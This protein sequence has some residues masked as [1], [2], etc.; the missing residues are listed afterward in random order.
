MRLKLTLEGQRGHETGLTYDHIC[1]QMA[2][3]CVFAFV[4][5]VGHRAEVPTDDV[6]EFSSLKNH[7]DNGCFLVTMAHFGHRS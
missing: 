1:P 6:S 7:F 2:F 5:L 3:L 4:S